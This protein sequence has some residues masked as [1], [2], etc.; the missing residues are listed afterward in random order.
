MFLAKDDVE[1]RRQFS[2]FVDPVISHSGALTQDY[3]GGSGS[4]LSL[5]AVGGVWGKEFPLDTWRLAVQL[6]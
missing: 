2:D 3:W 6:R 5:G 1:E 4:Q